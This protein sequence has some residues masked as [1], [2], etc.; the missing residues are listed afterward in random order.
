VL[1]GPFG[2]DVM[3]RIASSFFSPSITMNYSGDAVVEARVVS[4]VASFGK[5][6]GWLN[7]IVLDLAAGQ[8]PPAAALAQLQEAVREI[9]AIKAQARQ[10]A[11]KRANDALDRLRLEQADA[12]R[13]L[14][15]E[16]G[17]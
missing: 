1:R 9:E 11:C 12:Y 3:Q 6:L 10:S 17:G 15:R 13:Q 4:E 16:R 7:T 2:G 14:L 5:Q 8:P